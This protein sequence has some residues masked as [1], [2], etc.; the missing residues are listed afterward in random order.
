[1]PSALNE[2]TVQ[3]A[4]NAYFCSGEGQIEYR[5]SLEHQ[6]RMEHLE[7]R[8]GEDGADG[9]IGAPGADGADGSPGRDGAP[10]DPVNAGFA[11]GSF[12]YNIFNYRCITQWN[13]SL[14]VCRR[15]DGIIYQMGSGYLQVSP[16][17]AIHW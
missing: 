4:S 17:A 13:C 14:S 8:P 7:H 15:S 2:S 16:S 12:K 6:E 1:M 11:S 10:A 9:P 5:R 3:A